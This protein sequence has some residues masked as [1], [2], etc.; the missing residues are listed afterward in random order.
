MFV[1]DVLCADTEGYPQVFNPYLDSV[2]EPIKPFLGSA[3][4]TETVELQ[5]F[6]NDAGH[7][8]WNPMQEYTNG[9]S[10]TG[11]GE[12]IANLVAGVFVAR[13]TLFRARGRKF[14]SGLTESAVVGN[15]LTSTAMIAF[16]AGLTAY[17]T[18]YT[19]EAGSTL[20]PGV[21]GKD[22]N[23]HQFTSGFVS[24]LLGSMRR[25]KPGLGI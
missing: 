6:V 15:S 5:S 24:S 3:W 12:V 18:Q 10:G 17:I 11:S 7:I 21:I 19:T 2:T 14:W 25:R 1:A 8:I 13:S 4:T 9:S 20:T 22:G 16:L 23:F